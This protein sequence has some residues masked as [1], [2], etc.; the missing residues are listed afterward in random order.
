MRPTVDPRS[1]KQGDRIEVQLGDGKTAFAVVQ[2]IA[3]DRSSLMVKRE[4]R[5]KLVGGMATVSL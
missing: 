5:G 2:G 4:R 1:A 3:A